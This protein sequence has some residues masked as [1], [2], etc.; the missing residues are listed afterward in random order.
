MRTAIGTVFGRLTLLMEGLFLLHRCGFYWLNNFNKRNFLGLLEM[1]RS[2]Q[3]N[4]SSVIFEENIYL[5][6]F[7][8]FIYFIIFI[9]NCNHHHIP[10]PCQ[11]QCPWCQC[12]CPW[13]SHREVQE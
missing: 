5:F 7:N 6:D 4:F 2:D 8:C 12:Q 9:F 10:F 11:C 1:V 3:C 13:N